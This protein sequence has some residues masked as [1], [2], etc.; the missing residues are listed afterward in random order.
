MKVWYIYLIGITYFILLAF[1]VLT[2]FEIIT[3]NIN[4][5]IQMSFPDLGA[6][7]IIEL[8][9]YPIILEF[10]GICL[11]IVSVLFLFKL[12]F[13]KSFLFGVIGY[14]SAIIPFSIIN[15]ILLEKRDLFGSGEFQ[16]SY[17]EYNSYNSNGVQILNI[18]LLVNIFLLTIFCLNLI[19]LKFFKNLK[20]K[21][22]I[23]RTI[24][25]LGTQ[26]TRLQIREIAQTC[27]YDRST[28]I[29][30]VKEMIVNREIYGQYFRSSGFVVFNQKVNIEEI[31]KLMATYKEWEEKEDGKK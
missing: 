24:L 3:W 7:S 22:K 30:V 23:K 6:P 12:R 4:R 31:D 26:Y 1:I 10:F 13:I 5:N 8:I 18:V 17:D 20:K 11:L 25:D 14:Y 15:Q 2:F 27:K 19:F 21:M 29:F 16:V 28:I 9:N